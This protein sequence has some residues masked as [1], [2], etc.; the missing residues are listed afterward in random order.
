M[1]FCWLLT[2]LRRQHKH[3]NFFIEDE[4]DRQPL[5]L[6]R[7]I[8]LPLASDKNN[9]IHKIPRKYLLPHSVQF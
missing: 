8:I 7:C 2:Q 4:Q 9:V 6:S 1:A 5:A 3:F